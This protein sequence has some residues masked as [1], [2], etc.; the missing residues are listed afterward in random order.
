MKV[1]F[2]FLPIVGEVGWCFNVCAGGFTRRRPLRLWFCWQ[3]R[4]FSCSRPPWSESV[5]LEITPCLPSCR[6]F[7]PVSLGSRPVMSSFFAGTCGLGLLSTFF[8]LPSGTLELT[9][10]P[11]FCRLDQSPLQNIS[12]LFT[13]PGAILCPPNTL[14]NTFYNLAFP[15]QKPSSQSRWTTLP[16]SGCI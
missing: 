2:L 11:V 10:R 3:R 7:R 14:L 5:L 16:T 12:N 15:Y 6:R 4:R 1:A 8:P 9:L 13:I